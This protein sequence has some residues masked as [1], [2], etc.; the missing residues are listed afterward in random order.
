MK[1]AGNEIYWNCKNS[2]VVHRFAVQNDK[3]LSK[4][5]ARIVKYGRNLILPWII[6]YID[7]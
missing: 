2:H 6:L 3:H 5:L 1:D 7:I 4:D